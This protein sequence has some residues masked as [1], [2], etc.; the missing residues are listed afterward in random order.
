MLDEAEVAVRCP[1]C[2]YQN[3]RSVWSLKRDSEISC[4]SCSEVIRL[5]GTAT[6]FRIL[7]VERAKQRLNEAL[8]R[9]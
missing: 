3:R 2:G 9:L 8:S 5:E 1:K 6:G 7:D 4:G